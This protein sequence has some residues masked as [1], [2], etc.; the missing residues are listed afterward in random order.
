MQRKKRS[1]RK[2]RPGDLVFIVQDCRP[3]AVASSQVAR[4]K[5]RFEVRPG[6]RRARRYT[7]ARAG[8]QGS[9]LFQLKDGTF[10][11]GCEC[12][13][14]TK[15]EARAAHEAV[16]LLDRFYEILREWRGDSLNQLVEHI[17]SLETQHTVSEP[18]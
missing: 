4:Y 7:G 10:I 13:W 16:G 12:F 18:V 8:N 15:D 9:P 2:I 14:T 17:E 3:G 1:E 6:V 11:Y 5:G